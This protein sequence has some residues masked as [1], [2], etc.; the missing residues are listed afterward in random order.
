MLIAGLTGGTGSGK[1]TAARRFEQH[2]IAVVDADR[3]GHALIENGGAAVSAVLEHFGESVLTC[4]TIDRA[5]LGAIVFTDSRALASLNAI[6]KPLIA[7]AIAR[8]CAAFAE[9]DVEVTLVDGALLADSGKLEPWM[10][11]GLILIHSPIDLRVERLVVSRG[12]TEEQAR[13]RIASQ[14][15]P[16]QKRKLARWV[17]DNSG[18]VESLLEQVDEVARELTF[19]ARSV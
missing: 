17:L 5:K 9:M 1:S 15:D 3:E 6:M 2:G 14:V 11:G 13:Q 4:G 18:S 10:A 16:E 7:E 19:L 12:L 8:R